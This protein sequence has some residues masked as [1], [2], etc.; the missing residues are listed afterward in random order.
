MSNENDEYSVYQEG[1]E[2]LA[3][4]QEELNLGKASW[5]KLKDFEWELCVPG[6]QF[7]QRFTITLYIFKADTFEEGLK[8]ARRACKTI[9]PDWTD[10]IQEIAGSNFE[11]HC[12]W[13][14]D[15]HPE[16]L[17][18]LSCKADDFPSN[19]LSEGCQWVESTETSTHVGVVCPS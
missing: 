15:K 12:V 9:Y 7:F 10:S 11:R 2:E 14:C 16:I 6:R 3:K 18:R 19:I 17:I 13:G 8:E 1:L 4:H 5:E